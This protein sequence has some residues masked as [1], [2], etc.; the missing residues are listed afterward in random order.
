MLPKQGSSLCS[1]TVSLAGW[2]RLKRTPGRGIKQC[3]QGRRCV[4][5]L[6]VFNEMLMKVPV[7][8]F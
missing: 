3:L 1:W 8:Y 7:R 6:G 4:L 2:L 5:Q